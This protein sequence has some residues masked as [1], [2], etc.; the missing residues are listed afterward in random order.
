MNTRRS[1]R[2]QEILFRELFRPAPK[3]II[4]PLSDEARLAMLEQQAARPIHS[5][6]QY[7]I[8]RRQIEELRAKIDARA[9]VI[10]AM[11]KEQDPQPQPVYHAAAMAIRATMG[12][13]EPFKARWYLA[14]EH[15]RGMEYAAGHAD[16][17]WSQ[18][19]PTSAEYAQASAFL[20][21]RPTFE[22]RQTELFTAAADI[23]HQWELEATEIE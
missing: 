23:A 14:D 19:R 16:G 11:A 1:P 15:A 3:P 6:Q 13:L 21:S 2:N 22:G 4:Y 9:R 10:G 7:A 12:D 17:Y 20:A 8:Y 5:A 18:R